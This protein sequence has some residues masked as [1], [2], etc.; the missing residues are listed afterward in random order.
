MQETLL[1]YQ[2]LIQLSH[3]FEYKFRY[4]TNYKWLWAYLVSNE[5]SFIE[6]ALLKLYSSRGQGTGMLISPQVSITAFHVVEEVLNSHELEYKQKF[7][8]LSKFEQ[9]KLRKYMFMA[10]LPSESAVAKDLQGNTYSVD[11]LDSRSYLNSFFDQNGEIQYPKIISGDTAL[12][13]LDKQEATP[14]LEN[15]LVNNQVCP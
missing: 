7:L 9:F 13:V 10:E 4:L 6:R 12:V 1:Y 14:S 2:V 3:L 11:T 5:E 15:V 8:G